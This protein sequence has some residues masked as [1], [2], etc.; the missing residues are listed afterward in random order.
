MARN[1]LKNT[2]GSDF[3]ALFGGEIYDALRRKYSHLNDTMYR[4]STE[5]E[6][7]CEGFDYVF[8]GTR[9]DLTVNFAGKDHVIA[10][11]IIMTVPHFG[12]VYAGIRIANSHRL[13]PVP[14][15]VIG[16]SDDN[17]LSTRG[18]ESFCDQIR[19]HDQAREILE[20]AQNWFFAKC[21]ELDLA[22]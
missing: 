3:E 17:H 15:L 7:T 14:V 21:D 5:E 19:G 8:M 16:L 6:D 11:D 20:T 22:C 2:T 9:T 1:D 12:D 18:V 10:R 13:F 4:A